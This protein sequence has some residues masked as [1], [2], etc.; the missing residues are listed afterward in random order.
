[1]QPIYALAH[2]LGSVHLGMLEFSLCDIAKVAY[3]YKFVLVGY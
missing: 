1:M 2:R 3:L